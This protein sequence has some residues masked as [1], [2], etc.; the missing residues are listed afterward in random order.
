MFLLKGRFIFE[1]AVALT[2]TWEF[3]WGWG[4]GGGEGIVYFECSYDVHN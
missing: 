4:G 3:V 1:V 2:M